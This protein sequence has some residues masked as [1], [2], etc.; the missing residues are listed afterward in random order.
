[1]TR[2]NSQHIVAAEVT[3]FKLLKGCS[4]SEII[5]A[6]LP[7]LLPLGRNFSLAQ[8]HR[9][10][11]KTFNFRAVCLLYLAVA[12]CGCVSKKKADAQAHAAFA[13]G[14]QQ[15]M[16]LRAPQPAGNIVTIVGPVRIPSL[17]WNEGL[18]LAKAIV[19]CGYQ[20]PTDPKQIMIVRNGQAVPVDPRSLLAGEDVPLL[21]GDMVVFRQ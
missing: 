15:A 1:M 16:M 8:W 13:A 21:P 20:S 19:N 6:S 18:T 10:E 14:Q 11:L 5:R 2:K 3:R 7:R 9:F 12:F 17:P 4:G